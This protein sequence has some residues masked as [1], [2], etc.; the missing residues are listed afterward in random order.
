M[1]TNPA[2]WLNALLVL[3][4]LPKTRQACGLHSVDCCVR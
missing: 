4:F 3:L 1:M 2:V